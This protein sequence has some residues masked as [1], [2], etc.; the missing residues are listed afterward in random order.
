M[1]FISLMQE[2]GAMASVDSVPAAAV[3][4]RAI[5]AVGG[6]VHGGV[7]RSCRRCGR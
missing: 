4:V 5:G 1:T 6:G 2:R 7:P 3:A